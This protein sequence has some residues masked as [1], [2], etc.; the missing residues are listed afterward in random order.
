MRSLVDV[1]H[2]LGKTAT[3]EWVEDERTLERLREYG[4]DFAQ[5]YHLGRPRP[6]AEGVRA[7]ELGPSGRRPHAE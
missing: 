1:A 4:V 7:A 6:A 3:A 2:G 5:G